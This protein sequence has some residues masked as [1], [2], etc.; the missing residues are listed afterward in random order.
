MIASSAC[1][2]ERPDSAATAGEKS[3]R[4]PVPSRSLRML[5]AIASYGE[6]NIALLHKVIDGCRAMDFGVDIV[7][8]SNTPK[9]LGS[10]VD[11]VVGLPSRDPWSL[12][13]AHK[14]L[15]AR[16]V[17]HY[18]LFLYIEDDMGITPA[19]VDAFL[20]LTPYLEEDEVAGFL[21]FELD[22][23][24]TP[25]L[26][27]AHDRFH[28]QPEVG[29]RR[30]PYVVGQ[31]TNEHAGMY[32]LTQAQLRRAIATGN[33]LRPPCEGL[34]GMPE[35]AA[36]DPYTVCGLR[37]VICLSALDD[38]LIQ[39][40]SNRY[41]GKWG[42]PLPEFRQQVQ[43]QLDIVNGRHPATTLGHRESKLLHGELSKSYYEPPLEPVIGLVPPHAA[44]LLSIGCGWGATEARLKAR[45]MDVTVVPLDSIIGAA[46]A[47][48]GFEVV[49]GSLG[50]GLEALVGRRFDCVLI[51]N[52]LHLLPEP[53]EVL[54]RCSALVGAGGAVVVSGPNFR[55]LRAWAKRV[56]GRAG[57]EKLDSVEASGVRVIGPR[58]LLPVL[59]R[60]GFTTD[61][62]R[63]FETRPRKRI[64]SMFGPW[65][66]PQWALCA[67]A[68]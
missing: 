37:K 55:T 57:Y 50:E 18:D 22:E 20:R 66:A 36:T 27:D 62:V 64:E 7:V 15:F 3:G 48:H 5:V 63:W 68:L 25:V 13:F 65:G 58:E 67:R 9:D 45:G 28:L 41:Q 34:Y 21:R 19:H 53:E 24:M 11:V 43:T 56:L 61:A 4:A 14:S 12:T 35:T 52:L 60:A 30:G 31:F 44:S 47:R 2:V 59:V 54:L 39:H 49:Y 6:K 26:L 33:F 17:E 8:F 1:A 51:T 32:L 46:T 38:Y 29:R 23:T 10:D 40:L 16:R 42:V